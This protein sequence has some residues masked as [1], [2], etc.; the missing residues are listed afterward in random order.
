MYNAIEVGMGI[1]LVLGILYYYFNFGFRMVYNKI[2]TATIA[3]VAASLYTYLIWAIA[4][5]TWLNNIDHFKEPETLLIN[6]ACL[7]GFVLI[8]LIGLRYI[9]MKYTEYV[10]KI[11]ASLNCFKP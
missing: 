10:A 4:D 11:Q 1:V 6:L 7:M 8:Y 2:I 3:A 5:V 9:T